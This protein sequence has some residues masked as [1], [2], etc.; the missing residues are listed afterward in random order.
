[1]SR[2]FVNQ[3][4]AFTALTRRDPLL[5]IDRVKER[6]AA[7]GVVIVLTPELRGTHL[8]GAARWLSTDRALIQLSLRHKSDDQ[9]W[10]SLFHEC[11]HI[12]VFS[13]LQQESSFRTAEILSVHC[14][15]FFYR[16]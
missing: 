10:F 2:P 15:D 6:A 13:V 8:S 3:S 16:G 5:V 1:M 14:A 12:Y 4:T 9:F 11:R 7:S